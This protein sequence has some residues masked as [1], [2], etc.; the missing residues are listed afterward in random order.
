[1]S[2]FWGLSKIYFFPSENNHFG[3]ASPGPDT[4]NIYIP[5][6]LNLPPLVERI[7]SQG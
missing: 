3:R 2:L 6:M 7:L 5:S 1:M 4:E